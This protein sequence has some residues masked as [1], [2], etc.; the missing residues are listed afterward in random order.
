MARASNTGISAIFDQ[1]GREIASTEVFTVA[2]IAAVVP[3]C[4]EM[5][6]YARYGDLF[7]A[8]VTLAYGAAIFAAVWRRS[9]GA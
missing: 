5:T 4:T 9:R 7:L 1:L 2:T 8:V 6:F 3:I